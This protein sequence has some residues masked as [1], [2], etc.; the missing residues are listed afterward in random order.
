[1]DLFT[2][3][4]ASFEPVFIENGWYIYVESFLSPHQAHAYFATLTEEIA[5][6]QR[7][8]KSPAGEVLFPRLTA[9]YGDP[10]ASYSYSGNQF[11]PKTWTAELLQIKKQVEA[12]AQ[13]SFNSVLLNLYRNQSDSMGWHADDEK[14]LGSNPLIA[15]VNLGASR[16]FQL[17]HQRTKQ[18]LNFQLTNGSLL[19]MGGELQHYW[20]HQV[21]K[22]K[23]QLGP[24]INLTFRQIYNEVQ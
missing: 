2:E 4:P 5:W 19:I 21:P 17:K 6:E 12:L 14:E 16:L 24:R 23:L 8:I 1:M 3:L 20:L 15:S 18:R 9:W 7:S 22:S 10:Q 11:V 13:A